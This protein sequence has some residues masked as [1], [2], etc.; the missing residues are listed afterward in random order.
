MGRVVLQIGAIRVVVARRALVVDRARHP[1]RGLAHLFFVLLARFVGELGELTERRE[2]LQRLEAEEVEEVIRR[3]VDERSARLVALA[4]DP[5]EVALEED[6]E[7]RAAVDTAHVVDLRAGDGLSVG[8]DR[9]RLD[10]RAGELHRPLLREIADAR[11]V[12]RV[13]PEDPASGDIFEMDPARGVVLPQ[14]IEQLRDLLQRRRRE[15]REVLRLDRRVARKDERLEHPA[16]VPALDEEAVHLLGRI[17]LERHRGGIEV[18]AA[19]EGDRVASDVARGLD[20]F[21]LRYLERREQSPLTLES[22]LHRLVEKIRRQRGPRRRAVALDGL[23]SVGRRRRR[24]L[25]LHALGCCC[26]VRRRLSGARSGL[27]PLAEI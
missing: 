11:R 13:R 23:D 14:L 24:C 6:L 2:V 5:D 3:A 8:D 9:D 17:A 12:L 16:Q 15:L 10:L 4:E 27:L 1:V 22:R 21:D 19:G 26:C 18:I 25:V 7:H 20:V